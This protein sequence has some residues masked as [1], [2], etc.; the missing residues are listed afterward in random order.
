MINIIIILE[1]KMKNGK[2]EEGR[3]IRWYLEGKPHRENEPAIIYG[4]GTKEWYLHGKRHRE[5]GPARQWSD[6]LKEWYLEGIEVKEQ[7][8]NEWAA[9]TRLHEKLQVKLTEK[10][11]QKRLKI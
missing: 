5:D 2:Y 7:D 6:G 10:P 11:K 9:K 3:T 8:F 1:Y 4:D